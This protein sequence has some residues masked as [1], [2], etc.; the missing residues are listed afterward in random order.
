MEPAFAFSTAE[1]T[2]TATFSSY[3]RSELHFIMVSSTTVIDVLVFISIRH[4]FMFSLIFIFS[5]SLMVEY[6]VL[7]TVASTW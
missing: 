2:V 7:S 5:P 6:D 4:D 1:S 3:L